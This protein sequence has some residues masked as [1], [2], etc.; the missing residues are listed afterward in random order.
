MTI[1]LAHFAPGAAFSGGLVIGLAVSVLLLFSGRI[2]GISGILGGF[3]LPAGVREWRWRAAFVAGLVLSPVLVG[4]LARPGAAVVDTP[5]ALLVVAGLLVGYG[6]RLGSGCTSG[7]A[8]CGVARF[9]PRSLAAT[10]VFMG[11]G[12]LTVLALRH[13]PGVLP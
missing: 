7:H 3:L 6:A 13:L 9:S 1:D 8:V 5:L 12:I 2:A 4:A 10:A 11:T